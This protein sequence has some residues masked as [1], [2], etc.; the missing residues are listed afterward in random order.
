MIHPIKEL[1]EK[2]KRLRAQ[3]GFRRSPVRT[4]SRLIS[5][6]VTCSCRRT[7]TV[8][9]TRWDLRVLLPARWRGIGKLVFAFRECYEPEL[10]YLR[11]LLFPGATFVDVGANLGIYTLVASR[12]VGHSGRVIAFEPSSQS[13]SLLK[14]N[15]TLNGFTNVQV[16]PAAVSDKT[17]K[18]FLYHGPDPGHNSL[19]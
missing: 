7:A 12:I 6:G 1:L 19:G 2:W 10:E 5:W 18:A 15:I 11:S 4:V 17:G 14:A 9:L 16:Y 13:F 8:R 3:Y